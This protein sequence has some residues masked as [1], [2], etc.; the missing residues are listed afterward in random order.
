[1][2]KGWE[3]LEPLETARPSK[4]LDAETVVA[5]CDKLNELNRGLRSRIEKALR[6]KGRGF[7]KCADGIRNEFSASDERLFNYYFS[8]RAYS[9]DIPSQPPDPLDGRRAAVVFHM[10]DALQQTLI[11][12]LR[13]LPE[14]A[15]MNADS[16]PDPGE[17]TRVY[18]FTNM[19]AFV[20]AIKSVQSDVEHFAFWAENLLVGTDG[21]QGSFLST[22]WPYDAET[23]DEQILL[24]F[25]RTPS[26]SMLNSE[27]QSSPIVA[28]GLVRS[29]LEAVLFRKDFHSSFSDLSASAMSHLEVV[30]SHKASATSP[31]G[32]NPL[33]VDGWEE[34]LKHHR[35]A[36]HV[37]LE[38]NHWV[39]KL[40][41]LLSLA[42]HS[43]VMLSRGEIWAFRRVVEHLRN[44]LDQCQ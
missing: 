28:A 12:H 31:T 30:L 22:E 20:S 38:L 9:F 32:Q 4:A 10:S 36:G 35:E 27:Y 2:T 37:T 21:S 42:L 19:R 13:A 7:N 44:S 40:Y 25:K 23:M 11:C 5:A 14:A 29:Y 16:S 39:T 17:F 15:V 18:R 33:S 34:A 8:N 43:G 24:G 41:G 6:D 3:Y 26:P 1:M